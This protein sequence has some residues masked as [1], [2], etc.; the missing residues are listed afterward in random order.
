MVSP[1]YHEPDLLTVSQTIARLNIGRTKF[2]E[3]LDS[4]ELPFRRIRLGSHMRFSRL[5]VERFCHGDLEAVMHFG[6]R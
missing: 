5:E 3:M 1:S 2:Y 4:G 6:V